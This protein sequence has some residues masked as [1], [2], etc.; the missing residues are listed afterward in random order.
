MV[1]DK[2]KI[3]LFTNYS[4]VKFLKYTLDALTSYTHVGRFKFKLFMLRK[5]KDKINLISNN[6]TKNTTN[7][8]NSNLYKL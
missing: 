5:E 7:V 2:L 4:V 3:H 1:K 6:K 8:I